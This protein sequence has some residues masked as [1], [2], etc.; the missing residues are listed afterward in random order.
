MKAIFSEATLVP[1]SL[2]VG[3]LFGMGSLS[4]YT[5]GLDRKLVVLEAQAAKQELK[6]D[7]FDNQ[8]V[9]E[10]KEFNTRLS[11]IEG[12]LKNK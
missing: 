11:T 7:Q 4:F 3:A 2:V 8:L 9:K 6:F 10:F 12:M 5:G 1:V